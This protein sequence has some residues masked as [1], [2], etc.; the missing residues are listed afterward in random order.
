[1]PEIRVRLPNMLA[2]F[3]DNQRA[4]CVTA[5][6][7]QEALDAAFGAFPMLRAHLQDESGAQRPHVN[8]YYNDTEVRELA[9]RDA[10]VR[11]GDEIMIIQSVSGG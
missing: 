10:P 5:G 3:A 7:V 6:S 9:S 2:Q 11:A 4:F 1:M 8:V